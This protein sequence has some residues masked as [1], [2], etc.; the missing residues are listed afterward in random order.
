[1]SPRTAKPCVQPSQYVRSY[2]GANL[3]PPRIS[4][5]FACAS[6]GN[7]ES[8]VHELMSSGAFEVVKYF[9]PTNSVSPIPTHPAHF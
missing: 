1:M 3:P 4:S 7:C 2:P 5:A 9:Y 8:T 6:M